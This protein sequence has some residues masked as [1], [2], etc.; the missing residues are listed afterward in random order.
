MADKRTADKLAADSPV[1]G[2]GAWVNN[3]VGKAAPCVRHN[4]GGIS[5]SEPELGPVH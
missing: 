4:L 2:V 1:V 5:N 3:I